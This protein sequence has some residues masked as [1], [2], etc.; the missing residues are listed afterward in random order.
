M[1]PVSH[2]VIN[3]EETIGKVVGRRTAPDPLSLTG[4]TKRAMEAWRQTLGGV[5]IPRGVH[6]FQSHEEADAWLWKMI[7]RPRP[8]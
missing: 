4:S 1:D 8:S 5:R 2:A 7:A 3:V 6:R